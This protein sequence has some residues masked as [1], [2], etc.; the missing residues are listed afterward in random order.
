MADRIQRKRERKRARNQVRRDQFYLDTQPY[1]D[2]LRAGNMLEEG[3][4]GYWVIYSCE[5]ESYYALSGSCSR[6]AGRRRALREKDVRRWIKPHLGHK[7]STYQSCILYG[8]KHIKGDLEELQIK[9]S[10]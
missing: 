6:P 8:L 3:H 10:L 5:G 7:P 2:F 4:D 9:D 1:I